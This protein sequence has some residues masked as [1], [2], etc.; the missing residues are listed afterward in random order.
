MEQDRVERGLELAVLLLEAQGGVLAGAA[1]DVAAVELGRLLELRVTLVAPDGVVL[2]DSGVPGGDVRNMANHGGRP[3]IRQALE[4]E[5][6]VLERPSATTGLRSYYAAAPAVRDGDPL[7]VR[8]ALS[9][10]PLDAHQRSLAGAFVLL[11][12]LGLGG[13]AVGVALVERGP[14]RGRRRLEAA[15]VRMAGGEAPELPDPGELSPELV[16]LARALERGMGEVADRMSELER[17]RNDVLVLVDSIA[18]GVI[19][20]SED[21]RVFRM[22][23]AAADLL[24]LDR[25][26]PFAPV[27]TLVRHPGLRE[28]L[29]E[30]TI[31]PLPPREFTL[32]G[33][34]LLLS[35]RRLEPGGAVVTFLD[36]TELRRM[37][38][39]RRDFV[40]NAS[41]ELRTPLTAMRGFA[42]TLLEGDPPPELRTRFLE[43]I[44]RNSVRL[45]RLVDDLLDLSRLEAG[46]WEAAEEEVA[47]AEVAR[48]AW[49]ELEMEAEL[50]DIQARIEGE[51]VA[52]ADSRALHQIFR[53][54]FDNALRH[55]PDGGSVQVEVEAMGA[56]LEV[57]VIDSGE[58]IPSSVLPRIFERFYR[59]DA[60]RARG[61]GGTGLGLSIVRHMVTSMGGEVEARSRLGEGTTIAFRLPRVAPE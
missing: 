37:E 3:E 18:E 8:L 27:G 28:H 30:S 1:P 23:Q 10:D 44:R 29:E 9:L 2:G 34:H 15:L 12:V 45:Q 58:G 24:D 19:A 38:K 54:L 4:G 11:G 16:P 13:L 51:E 35:S 7:I 60:G 50:R 26:A 6:V 22:N 33:R 31:L 20:L 47:P 43:S 5:S 57:R 14:R 53:N 55:T 42:E 46:A 52:L 25:P 36:V 17:E 39:I 59:G 21:A 56:M 48:E 49:A 41:H 32:G 40:A 61:S